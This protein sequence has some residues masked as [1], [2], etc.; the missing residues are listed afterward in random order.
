MVA[1]RPGG[2]LPIEGREGIKPATLQQFLLEGDRQQG[3]SAAGKIR[4]SEK[5][6]D[7]VGNRTRDLPAC[8]IVHQ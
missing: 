8:S 5:S 2:S 3:R 1:S 6:S 7:L 4:S